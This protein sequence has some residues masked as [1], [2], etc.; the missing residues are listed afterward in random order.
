MGFWVFA[1]AMD[2]LIPAV[3]I[4]FGRR[5][6]RRPP[7]DISAVYGY[8]TTMS[9]K[10][11]DTWRFAHK[12]CGRLWLRIGIAA[13]PVSVIPLL[14]VLGRDTDTVGITCAAVCGAQVALM[15]LTILPVERA[16][17]KRFDSFGR[18]K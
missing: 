11:R 18:K 13:A 5:F 3:M 17:R 15:L 9:M 7:K 4:C 8:R 6:L 16:L 14:C 1:M 2:L 12:Y 10:N